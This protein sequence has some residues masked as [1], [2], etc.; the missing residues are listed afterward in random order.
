MSYRKALA[1][2]EG[3]VSAGLGDRPLQRDLAETLPIALGDMQLMLRD[4]PAARECF[5]RALII[6][7]TLTPVRPPTETDDATSRSPITASATS[8][9]RLDRPAAVRAIERAI[10]ILEPLAADDGDAES[11]QALARSYEAWEYSGELR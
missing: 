5:R 4:M 10:A 6:R 1:L 3:L 2:Q 8:R 9:R 11:R 7:E